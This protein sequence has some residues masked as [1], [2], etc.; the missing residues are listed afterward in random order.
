MSAEILPTIKHKFAVIKQH[1]ESI[2]RD[3]ESIHRTSTAVC[4]IGETDE[5]AL[6]GIPDEFRSRFGDRLKDAL[7]GSPDTIRQRLQAYEE[8]G[9]QELIL[10]FPDPTNLDTIR[11]FAEENSSPKASPIRGNR[12]GASPCVRPVPRIRGPPGRS[13]GHAPTRLP[14]KL[15]CFYVRTYGIRLYPFP[16]FSQQGWKP[17]RYRQIT[18]QKRWM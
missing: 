2:G 3:Y 18:E 9:V 1:C 5:L 12:V 11:F 13:P 17:R 8:A 7:I 16:V 4:A 6:A 10:R 15:S 14:M